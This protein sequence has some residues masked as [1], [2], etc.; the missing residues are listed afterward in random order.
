MTF[1]QFLAG[2]IAT[3]ALIIAV[4]A[5]PLIL[6]KIPPNGFYGFRTAKTMSDTTIWYDA[7]CFAG[8]AMVVAAIVMVSLA[9]MLLVL[10]AMGLPKNAISALGIAFEIAPMT[11]ATVFAF[12]Y[13][14]RYN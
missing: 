12:R 6:R 1:A 7:N 10:S 3:L 8:K 5:V 4:V 9:Y 13:L 2:S 11:V 14:R